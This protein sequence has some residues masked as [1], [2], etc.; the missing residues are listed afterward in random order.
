MYAI[1]HDIS[2]T[3]VHCKQ[4]SCILYTEFYRSWSS[5][6]CTPFC[7]KK[8]FLYFS[9]SQIGHLKHLDL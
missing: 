9:D 5:G 8:A 2:C 3:N 4:D 7:V 6:F 1:L